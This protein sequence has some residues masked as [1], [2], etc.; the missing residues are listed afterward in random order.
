MCRRGL[1]GKRRIVSPMP[2]SRATEGGKGSHEKE[3]HPCSINKA[4]FEGKKGSAQLK[5]RRLFEKAI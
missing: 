3:Q 1:L 5:S 2:H 4:G